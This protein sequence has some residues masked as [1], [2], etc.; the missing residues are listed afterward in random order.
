MPASQN[1]MK[2]NKCSINGRVYG[3]GDSDGKL[4]K[5]LDFSTNPYFESKFQFYDSQ[6]LTDTQSGTDD[7]AQFWR[8]LAL[9]HTVRLFIS[10]P[11]IS[12]LAT[13]IFFQVMPDLKDGRLRYQAQSPDE[14]ALTS[15]ARNFAFVFKSR[16]PHS[17]T[18]E[19]NGIDEI[20]EVLAILDFNNVRKRMSVLVRRDGHIHLYTKGAD[21]LVLAL[22]RNDPVTTQLK[23]LTQAH[24]DQFA[25]EGLRTLVCAYK[26]VSADC[27]ELW[28]P[29]LEAAR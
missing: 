1:V 6:L 11:I 20:Y 5:P 23:V 2:F 21:T 25:S 10:I 15:A 12:K 4:A 24:L 8:L 17:I 26:E 13:N 22:L 9:C 14:D 18:I 28:R 16:T 29:R 3:E 7:V 27:Y 19:V